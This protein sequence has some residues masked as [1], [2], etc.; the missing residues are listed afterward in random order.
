LEP[1]QVLA[2]IGDQTWLF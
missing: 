1:W 2:G